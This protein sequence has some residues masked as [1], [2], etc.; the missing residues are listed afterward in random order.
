M[1]QTSWEA[2]KMLDVYIYDYM[3]KRNLQESA[4]AF[5][6]EAKV[7]SDPV[8]IDA[9]G[10][11]LFEWWSDFWDIFIARKNDKHSQVASSYIETQLIK[12]REQQQM[13]P[14]QP[15]NQQEQQMQMQKLLLQKHAKQLQQ[16]H[17]QQQQHQLQQRQREGVHLLNGA[18]GPVGNDPFIRKNP[19]TANALATK[20]CEERLKL[21]P[22]RA[23]LDDMSMKQR[24]GDYASQLLDSNHASILKSATT[25]GQASGQVLH[26]IAGGMSGP[27]QQVE[28]GNQ[29]LSGA[30]PVNI[31][32]H[33]FFIDL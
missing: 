2:D 21:P 17:Q 19:G 8:A 15:Q 25:P 12:A 7:S 28:A 24:F 31:D 4:K 23:S 32:K 1:S 30:V 3:V 33:D 13:Q 11:F 6:T 29:Q 18:T 27:L 20:M 14:Q 9:P 26:G 22:Q 16:Q 5:Y 10:G